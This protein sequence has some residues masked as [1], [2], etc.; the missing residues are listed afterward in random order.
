M[1]VF[2]CIEQRWPELTFC[3]LTSGNRM[4]L[5]PPHRPFWRKVFRRTVNQLE[6][7]WSRRPKGL[8]L[9][10]QYSK[11]KWTEIHW[12]KNGICKTPRSFQIHTINKTLQYLKCYGFCCLVTVVALLLVTLNRTYIL[13]NVDFLEYDQECWEMSTFV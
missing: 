7:Q 4:R 1:Q 10:S 8:F 2:K 12:D 5:I 11:V 6:T 13:S 3:T 9:C